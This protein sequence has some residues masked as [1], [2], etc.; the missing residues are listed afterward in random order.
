MSKA[1]HPHPAPNNWPFPVWKSYP[2]K[3]PQPVHPDAPF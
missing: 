1:V 2:Y 3:A